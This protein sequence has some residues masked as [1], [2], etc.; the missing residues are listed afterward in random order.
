MIAEL[1]CLIQIAYPK[2]E[3]LEVLF[4]SEGTDCNEN[5]KKLR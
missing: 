3:S 4:W 1:N 2:A 5:K